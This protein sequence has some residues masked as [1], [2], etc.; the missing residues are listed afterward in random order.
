MVLILFLMMDDGIIQYRI[1][2]DSCRFLKIAIVISQSCTRVTLGMMP[3]RTFCK[4]ADS[5]HAPTIL[6]PWQAPSPPTVTHDVGLYIMNSLTREKEKF[7]TIDG[8]SNVRW[9]M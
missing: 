8:G 6:P 4:M 7:V 2:N 3:H 5:S 9:Y 1:L